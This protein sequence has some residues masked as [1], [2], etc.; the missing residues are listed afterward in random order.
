MEE[1]ALEASPVVA[2]AAAV[3]VVGGAEG[4]ADGVAGNGEAGGGVIV[5]VGGDILLVATWLLHGKIVGRRWLADDD[6]GGACRWNDR[7][8]TTKFLVGP[9]ASRP[10]TRACWAKP[11]AVDGG[12]RAQPEI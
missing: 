8:E 7:R 4:A 5:G 3:A 11:R 9:L 12:L 1:L 10:A 2:A 6:G